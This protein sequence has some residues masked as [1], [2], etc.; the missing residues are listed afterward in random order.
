MSHLAVGVGKLYNSH[1]V[2]GGLVSVKVAELEKLP[3]H[4][5]EQMWS[6]ECRKVWGCENSGKQGGKV[7][8]GK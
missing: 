7:G 5:K 3:T 1:V 2:A 4:G 8:E 6:H